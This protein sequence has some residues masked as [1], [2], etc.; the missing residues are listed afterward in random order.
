[1]FDIIL[2]LYKIEIL[3][4]VIVCVCHVQTFSKNRGLEPL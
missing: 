4:D 1:M 2:F 3:E